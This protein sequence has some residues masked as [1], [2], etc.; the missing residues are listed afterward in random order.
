MPEPDAI[1]PFP[2]RAPLCFALIL[3]YAL[4]S[5]CGVAPKYG[6]AWAEQMTAEPGECPEPER[7]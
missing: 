5:G 6:E 3:L 7:R 4:A 1:Q 2:P